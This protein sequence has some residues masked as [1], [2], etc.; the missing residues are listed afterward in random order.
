M[1]EHWGDT[2]LHAQAN[3]PHGRGRNGNNLAA[4]HL[5]AL[6]EGRPTAIRTPAFD[7]EFP[8]AFTL[9]NVLA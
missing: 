9:A 4:A 6:G 1:L 5:R 8:D 7:H 2:L 3:R